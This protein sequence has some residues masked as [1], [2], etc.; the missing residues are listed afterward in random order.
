MNKIIFTILFGCSFLTEAFILT[1]N[2]Q[3]CEHGSV[4]IERLVQMKSCIPEYVSYIQN[5]NKCTF[6]RDSEISLCLGT[7]NSHKFICDSSSFSVSCPTSTSTTTTT[8]SPTTVTCQPC[9]PCDRIET[10]SPLR[11]YRWIEVL[12]TRK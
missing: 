1:L 12:Q 5:G 3:D 7:L 4:P 8:A 2:N 11:H 6:I 10:L 9:I